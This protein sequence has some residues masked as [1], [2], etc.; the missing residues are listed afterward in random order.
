MHLQF[1][2]K[3]GMLSAN[4]NLRKAIALVVDKNDLVNRVLAIPGT[5]VSD[6]MFH[7]WMAVGEKPRSAVLQPKAHEPDIEMAKNYV[8]K[9]KVELGITGRP[10]MTFTIFDSADSGRIAEYLQQRLALIDVDLKIDPQTVQ[11]LLDKWFKGTTDIA[12]IGWIPDVD[13]PIDQLS[14]LGNPDIRL[15]PKHI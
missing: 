12:L 8:Q 1:S 4:E 7:D 9:A 13:D 2:H 14:C 3:E 5:R 6:S 10:T 15:Y 11:M